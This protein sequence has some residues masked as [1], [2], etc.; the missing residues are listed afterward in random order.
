[1]KKASYIRLLFFRVTFFTFFAS[2]S[3][4]STTDRG[5]GWGRVVDKGCPYTNLGSLYLE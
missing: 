1:M 4:S 3:I 2:A 5:G